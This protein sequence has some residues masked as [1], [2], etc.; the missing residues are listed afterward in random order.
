M[1]RLA[2]AALLTPV[3][4]YWWPGIPLNMSQQAYRQQPVQDQWAVRVAHYMPW[5]TYWWNTQKLFPASGVITHNAKVF[6]NQDKELLP[7]IA[8]IKKEYQVQGF[9]FV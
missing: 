8:A 6:S 5:L 3:V 9:A 2:G 7:R 1:N 4:N